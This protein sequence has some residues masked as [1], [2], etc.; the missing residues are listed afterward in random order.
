MVYLG[1][2]WTMG[3]NLLKHPQRRNSVLIIIIPYSFYIA[4]IFYI[5]QFKV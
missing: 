1:F 2:N 4:F 5:A 3:V